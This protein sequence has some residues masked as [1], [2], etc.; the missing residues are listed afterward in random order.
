MD[1]PQWCVSP[2]QRKKAANS[3]AKS[4]NELLQRKE[5]GVKMKINTEK[6]SMGKLSDRMRE[7]VLWG[8]CVLS[9]GSGVSKS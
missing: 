8:R 6:F 5:N 1:T 9:K 2:S 4:E 3:V 7:R